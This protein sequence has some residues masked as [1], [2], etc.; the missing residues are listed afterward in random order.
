MEEKPHPILYIDGAIGDEQ[1]ARVQAL[2]AGTALGVTRAL[3]GLKDAARGTDNLM[4]R[5][6]R[7]PGPTPRWARC[8][9]P[10]ARSSAST[11]KPPV[12]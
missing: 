1:V 10:C 3:A 5:S 2:R 7:P 9:T 6:S 11:K 12:F 4:P 8:A